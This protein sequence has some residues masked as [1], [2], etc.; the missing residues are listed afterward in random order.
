MWS[1]V[2]HSFSWLDFLSDGNI[3]LGD[4]VSDFIVGLDQIAAQAAERLKAVNWEFSFD[5]VVFSNLSLL[6]RLEEPWQADAAGEPEAQASCVDWGVSLKGSG[7]AKSVV[8]LA[9]SDTRATA[10]DQ[11]SIDWSEACKETVG[12]RVWTSGWLGDNLRL[13]D[14]VLES[15]DP[16]VDVIWV[17]SGGGCGSSG[18]LLRSRHF[19]NVYMSG[20]FNERKR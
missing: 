8:G 14:S 17:D 12:P 13:V 3:A 2:G 5:V 1:L 16:G 15:C 19:D 7:V 11:A 4:L 20:C 6:D 9:K 18:V 10:G